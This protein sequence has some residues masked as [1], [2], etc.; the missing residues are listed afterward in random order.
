MCS[1]VALD[2]TGYGSSP[3][4]RLMCYGLNKLAASR[5]VEQAGGS[6]ELLLRRKSYEKKKKKK[7]EE[8]STASGKHV[9]L[10]S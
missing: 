9:F 4:K 5:S 1:N 2:M 3:Y 7:Q 8:E 6:R 10:F